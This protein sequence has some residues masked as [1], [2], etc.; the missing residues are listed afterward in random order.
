M[1]IRSRHPAEVTAD[2][3]WNHLQRYIWDHLQRY[4]IELAGPDADTLVD[5]AILL[6]R[7]A[8]RPASDST[9]KG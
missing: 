2:R 7:L 9:P 6:R 1:K 8:A 5:A 4:K 3:I